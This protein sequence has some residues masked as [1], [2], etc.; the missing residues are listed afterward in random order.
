[1]RG[2]RPRS[3]SSSCLPVS[4]TPHA[5]IDLRWPSCSTNRRCL[6][7]MRG[8]R[9]FLGSG[10]ITMHTF[11]RMR[12]STGSIFL[13]EFAHLV[14]PACAGIDR[15]PAGPCRSARRLP[16]MRG[17]RPVVSALLSHCRM[18]TPHARGSTLG[19]ESSGA[20]GAVYPAC[21]GIDPI[22]FD[23]PQ[24]IIGLP[25]MRGDR[26]HQSRAEAPK[27]LFTPHAGDRPIPRP[28]FIQ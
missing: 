20:S 19:P 25:R 7:R 4:F 28:P 14:Y 23:D 21:A 17:D 12:G 1:M 2:D 26:P 15:H 5:G 16:R 6:P 13:L 10:T 27:Y 11:T 3:A 8:D 22:G 18:F 9:P 24:W